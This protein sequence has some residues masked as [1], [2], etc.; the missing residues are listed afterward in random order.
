MPLEFAHKVSKIEV[1]KWYLVAHAEIHGEYFTEVR[2]VAILPHLHK[3]DFAEYVPIHYHLDNRFTQSDWARRHYSIVDA[4]SNFPVCTAG[5]L[6]IKKIVFKRKKCVRL[7]TGLVVKNVSPEHSFFIWY[8]S[9]KG[10]SCKGKKC[11]HFGAIMS[12]IDGQLVCPMHG[13]IG[14][15]KTEKII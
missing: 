8:N 1:G 2:H 13:L 9:M 5:G 3:D 12:E 15:I 11:P 7:D 10:K 4:K 6:T 14:D